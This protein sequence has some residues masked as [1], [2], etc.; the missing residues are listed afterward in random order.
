MF[1]CG[2]LHDLGKL[3]L[4][5]DKE[6]SSGVPAVIAW[7]HDPTRAEADDDPAPQ[8]ARV[9][10]TDSAEALD[11]TAEQLAELLHEF[12]ARQTAAYCSMPR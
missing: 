3:I 12:P 5:D 9:A 8:A 1:T 11:V 2:F 6:D 7:Y 10:A 4:L